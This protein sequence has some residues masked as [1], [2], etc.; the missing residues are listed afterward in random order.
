M[1]VAILGVGG[2]GRT[3]ASELRADR[4]VTSLLLADQ[5]GER[6]RVLTGI[7]GRVS[8]EATQLNV[9]NRVSLEKALLGADIVVNT[10]LPKYNL[11]IMQAALAIRASYLDFAAGGPREPG[12]PEGIFEQLAMGDAFKAMGRTALL[13]M[14]LDPGVSN[15]MAREAADRFEAIDAIRIRTGDV[16]SVPGPGYFPLH[17]RETFLSDV[18]VPPSVWL[19]GALQNRE[20]LSEPEDFAFPPPVGTVRTYLV[21]HEGVKTLPQSLGKSVGRVDYKLALDPTLVRAL[22][23]LDRLDLLADSRMIRIGNQMVSFRRALLAAFPEPSA[24]VLP[25]QGATALSVEVEGR[26]GGRRTVRRGDVVLP[27]QEANRRRSTTAGYYLSA[28]GAAIG[29]ALIADE[30][31][32]GPGVYPPEAL[33]PT[34]VF[35]EWSARDLPMEW[36]E[37]S[38]DE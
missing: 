5:F 23:S 24:L 28:V 19:D 25:L 3:L 31:V 30:A 8:I 32:P 34:R 21:A 16:A 4:R 38:L 35:K 2:L 22:I 37:R 11:R 15:V 17:S 6:A 27:H 7:P 20:P 13:S 1:R 10:T 14:G 33:D 12:G 26:T 36:S 9:E 29:V 18:L